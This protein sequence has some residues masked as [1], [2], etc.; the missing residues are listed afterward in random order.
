MGA[1]VWLMSKKCY[2]MAEGKRITGIPPKSHPPP[3]RLRPNSIPPWRS[4]ARSLHLRQALSPVLGC[5]RSPRV[6][7]RP[8]EGD[9]RV[10]RHKRST[11]LGRRLGRHGGD[12]AVFTASFSPFRCMK[13]LSR[14]SIEFSS[15][16]KALSTFELN[17]AFDSIGMPICWAPAVCLRGRPTHLRVQPT[18][19]LAWHFA[20]FF[21]LTLACSMSVLPCRA[22]LGLSDVALLCLASPPRPTMHTRLSRAH[23]HL[24]LLTEPQRLRTDQGSKAPKR[25]G[26]VEVDFRRK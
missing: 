3:S 15:C 7:I 24:H 26:W 1:N 16:N 21:S 20:F 11:E 22:C 6:V 17:P 13:C 4:S 18:M 9:G 2:S 19:N 25:V 14:T 5:V 10:E 12:Y 8:R 23:H